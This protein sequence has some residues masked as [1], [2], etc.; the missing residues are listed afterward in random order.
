L[1]NPGPTNV[2]ETVRNALIQNDI[3]HREKEFFEVILFINKTLVKILGVEK[4]HSAILF[5]SSGTGCNEAIINGIHG[6][7]LLLNNGKYSSRLGDIAK[8]Y[9]IPLVVF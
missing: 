3:C 4:T 2:S 5:G 7:I 1:F 9:N 8:R 6:K